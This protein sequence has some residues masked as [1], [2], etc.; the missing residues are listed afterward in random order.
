MLP[1]ARADEKSVCLEFQFD[2]PIPQGPLVRCALFI[3][4]PPFQLDNQ[5]KTYCPGSQAGLEMASLAIR[6]IG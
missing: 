3:V 4:N 5:A 6:W 2:S 1:S